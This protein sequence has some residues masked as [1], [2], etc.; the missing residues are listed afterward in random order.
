M[1]IR[2][3][4]AM[5]VAILIAMVAVGGAALAV[6]QNGHKG[7]EATDDLLERT[8]STLGLDPQAMKDALAQAQSEQLLDR[9]QK[10][11]A[12]LVEEGVIIQEQA[13]EA[14]EWL[15]A[16]P[17]AVD[18]LLTRN[19]NLMLRIVSG[20]APVIILEAGHNLAGANLSD[21]VADR[22]S[23]ILGIDPAVLRDALDG[24]RNGQA[25]DQQKDAI[26][27]VITGL[28]NDGELTPAEG[29]EIKAWIEGI[30]DWV[31][32]H[33]LLLDLLSGATARGIPPGFGGIHG[34]EGLLD[35]PF[36]RNLER[37]GGPFMPPLRGFGSGS[38]RFFGP[39]GEHEGDFEF[40]QFEFRNPGD[41]STENRFFYS[42]PEGQ[43]EFNG[44]VPPEFRE[45]FDNLKGRFGDDSQVPFD[46][47]KFL[48]GRPFF[49]DPPLHEIPDGTSEGD[50]GN[51][52]VKDA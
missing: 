49:D 34:L 9:Q 8:A 3:V 31:K 30:P 15:N 13:D 38:E 4:P 50:I 29:D 44:E 26:D 2:F 40:P 21:E 43:F 47:N 39:D 10:L 6:G 51:E 17:A 18:G 25:E 28:V 27:D 19:P 46:L 42:G 12:G 35:Q 7:Q 45:L 22:M 16:K 36:F 14:T 37:D 24:A 5:L 41:D 11:I 1:S 23:E 48:E 33:G 20:T 52:S 32:D